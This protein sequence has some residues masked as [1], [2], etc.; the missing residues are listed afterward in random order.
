MIKLFVEILYSHR[1]IIKTYVKMLKKTT[2]LMPLLH[3]KQT[4]SWPKYLRYKNLMQ[5]KNFRRCSTV[6]RSIRDA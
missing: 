1:N 3:F 6:S 2:P 5:D 4:L